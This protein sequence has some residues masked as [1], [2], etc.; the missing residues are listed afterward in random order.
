MAIVH[1]D[2]HA[3]LY[4]SYVLQRWASAAVH[5]LRG[6]ARDIAPVVI[7]LDREG[8][9]S[10]E[11]L[12]REA[13]GWY[14]VCEGRVGIY[15]GVDGDLLVMRGAQYVAKEKIEVLALGCLR[16][17]LEGTCAGEIVSAVRDAGGVPCLPWSPGKWL[18]ARGEVVRKLL[19]QGTPQDL[20]V[21]DVAIR[22][23]FGPP[24]RLLARA[25]ALGYRVFHGTDPLPFDGE[26]ALVGSF[27]QEIEIDG[28]CSTD[29]LA[30]K[31]LERLRDPG[32]RLVTC[33]RRNGVAH[34]FRRFIASNVSRPRTA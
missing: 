10:F 29:L 7:V 30:E 27:G 22:S 2:A 33:G 5:N 34:A 20:S 26:E 18:G 14:E 16:V 31:V 15:Q 9:D 4:D 13:S 19:E 8:Q 25:R 23:R 32:C 3:H 17:G 12:R 28:S 11:R 24:S 1:L 21:G 6:G